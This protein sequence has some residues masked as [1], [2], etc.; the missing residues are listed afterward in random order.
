MARDRATILA[1]LDQV[2]D[3]LT[4][5]NDEATRL[6]AYRLEL[7]EEGRAQDP[8]ITQRELAAHAKVSE[9]AVIQVLRKAERQRLA[10]AHLAGEHRRGG[11]PAC[12]ECKKLE[13][14]TA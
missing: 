13:A 7:L 5:V 6:Y 9:E 2:A 8:P 10:E 12:P 1:L 11:P 4:T 14:R 3:E